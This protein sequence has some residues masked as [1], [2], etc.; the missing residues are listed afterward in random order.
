V[1]I[2]KATDVRSAICTADADTIVVRGEDLCRDLIGKVSFSEFFHLALTG[3]RPT[4]AA[5]ALLDATLV[6]IA[7]H[8]LVP[9]VQASRMTF[10]AA[11]DALQGA[12]A[13][14]I[15]G[16]GSVILGASETAAR[17]FVEIEA[18]MRTGASIDDASLAVVRAWREAK[19]AIP[20][21][22]HPLHKARDPRAHR[23]FDV[24]R[25]QRVDLR[26]VEIA[27]AVERAIPQVLDRKLTINVSAA[28]PAVLLGV[29]FPVEAMRGVPILA[30]TAG[31]I[32]HLYEETHKPIGFALAYN[33]ERGGQYDGEL[34]AGVTLRHE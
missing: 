5:L 13:A 20:G 14:G 24:A 6:A 34:P 12:V 25:E 9:S 30:R 28:I 3:K 2:G 22:G 19:R 29:G 18:R 26:Y 21:Y 17:L 11:P 33:A 10:A 23:L 27:Q 32:A 15:L 1:K 8:G 16:C 7:E 4:P 31:L